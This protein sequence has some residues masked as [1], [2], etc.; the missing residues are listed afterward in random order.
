VQL[1]GGFLGASVSATPFQP[2]PVPIPN[3]K[4]PRGA[5]ASDRDQQMKILMELD[6]DFREEYSI[7]SDIA[8]RTKAYE[9]AARMQLSA[10]EVVDFS[11]EPQHVKDASTFSDPVDV[12]KENVT[13]GVPTSQPGGGAMVLL[14]STAGFQPFSR[15]VQDMRTT[16]RLPL[17][18]PV[19]AGSMTL[20][21]DTKGDDEQV[22]VL[23]LKVTASR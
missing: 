12:S 16:I 7:N 14:P 4:P 19:I 22:M 11:K 15:A 9:L 8:A 5:S 23:I 20:K 6:S 1:T 17:G 10:P 18:V 21:P 2:G 3:L 13:I